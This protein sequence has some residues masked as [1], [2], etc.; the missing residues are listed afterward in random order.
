M[1]AQWGVLIT[2]PKNAA[3]YGRLEVV[4]YLLGA[5]ADVTVAEIKLR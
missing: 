3:Y 4:K 1:P 5:G 2:F